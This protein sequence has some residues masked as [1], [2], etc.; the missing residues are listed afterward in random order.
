MPT[1]LV[2]FALNLGIS[3]AS[4]V[5]LGLLVGAVFDLSPVAQVFGHTHHAAG[6]ASGLWSMIP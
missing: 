5:A 6:P 3:L 2:D 1:R 4:A